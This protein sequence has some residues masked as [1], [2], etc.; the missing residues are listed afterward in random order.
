[1]SDTVTLPIPAAA[2]APVLPAVGPLAA[3]ATMV[4][5]SLRL[6][7]RNVDGLIIALV[8]PITLMLVF[9]HLFGGAI[10]TG[11]DYVDYVVPGVLLLCT[12][13]GASL[14]AVSV[15][16]DLTGG[17]V[18]RLRSMD[19]GALPLLTGHVVAGVVRNG[20]STA[21]VL[22]VAVLNGF[23][24]QASPLGWLAALGLLALYVVAMSW[25]SAAIGLLV[26]SPEAAGGFSFF[27]LFLPYPSSG[28]VAVDT[29]PG[30]LQGFAEHQPLTPVIGALRALLLD[31]PVGDDA[32]LAVA[33]CGGLLVGSMVASAALFRHRFH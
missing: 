5:R 4:R 1:M 3:T 31:Q 13:Y 21:L 6:G 18:D 8:L 7:L 11:I 26:R 2:P 10:D 24:P 30:W 14:T 12:G 32:A 25:V 15:S 28:F 33:W 22:A 17:I 20:L 27:V 19:V 16:E 29:M 9:V 23:R